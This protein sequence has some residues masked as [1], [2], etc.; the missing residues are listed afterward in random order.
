MHQG[1]I[2]PLWRAAT[3]LLRPETPGGAPAAGLPSPLPSTGG[4]TLPPPSAAPW[5]TGDPEPLVRLALTPLSLL[6][7]AATAGVAQAQ[8][9]DTVRLR[10]GDHIVGEVKS[11]SKALLRYSTDDLGTVY[12]EWDK[13]TRIS[14][15]TILEV[16]LRSG[17]KFY[18]SL[19]P[20]PAGR[21][22]VSG[23]SLPLAD[24]VTM[25]PIRQRV[26][27][28]VDG[29]L[30]LGFS[31]QK[32]HSAIQ[33]SSGVK[34]TYR[35][36]KAESQ[37]QVTSFSEDRDD[38]TA[39]SRLST[40]FT[41]RILFPSRWSGGVVVGY[42]NNDELDLAGRVRVVPFGARTVV[43][44]NHVQ[45]GYTG[46]LVLARERYYSTDTATVSLEALAGVVFNAYRYDQP[47]LDASL[48]SELFP[49]LTIA[50]RVRWQN[51]FRVSYELVKDFMLTAS[52]F[53]SFDNKPQS[54]GAPKNDFGTTLAVSWTY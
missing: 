21:L 3:I 45:F 51:D 47:K 23:V 11:L 1:P 7:G 52:I 44:T 22:L 5:A 54:E 48:R 2:A 20:A 36:P 35:G 16:Q 43:E 34:A 4:A 41:E 40:A 10:N 50:K 53:D 39:T 33:I 8:K 31:Y 9:A 6:L 28:R 49:S 24:V 38:A 13:V 42:D 46:G 26:R 30:D 18:G 37:I 12:I 27:D 19:A 29:Y 15:K 14:T 17:L 32:A 25:V